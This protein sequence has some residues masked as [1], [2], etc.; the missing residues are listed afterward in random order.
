QTAQ[1]F[2][3]HDRLQFPTPLGG[4]T[5]ARKAADKASSPNR[6]APTLP[7]HELLANLLGTIFGGGLVADANQEFYVHIADQHVARRLAIAHVQLREPLRDDGDLE[8]IAS[9]KRGAIDNFRHATELV[10]LVE[11]QEQFVRFVET[12]QAS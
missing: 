8:A 7:P 5:G 12:G 9:D 10:E 6:G 3:G 2:R 4:S 1:S 11:H